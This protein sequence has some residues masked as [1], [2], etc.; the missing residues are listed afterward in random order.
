M[1]MLGI[2]EELPREDSAAAMG[3]VTE[4]SDATVSSDTDDVVI[5][6]A[7]QQ[8]KQKPPDVFTMQ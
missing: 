4:N 6:I 2:D 8:Q 5:A 7:I 1:S 3:S